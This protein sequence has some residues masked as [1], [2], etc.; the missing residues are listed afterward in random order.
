[1]LAD[2]LFLSPA[3]EGCVGVG[4]DCSTGVVLAVQAT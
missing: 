3:V 4:D 1:M 2:S